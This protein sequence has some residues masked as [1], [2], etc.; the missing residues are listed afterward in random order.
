MALNEKEKSIKHD[1]A[2]FIPLAILK[3]HVERLSL[4]KRLY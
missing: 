2:M 4:M 1:A 3:I